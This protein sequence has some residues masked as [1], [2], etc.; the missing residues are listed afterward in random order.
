MNSL[1]HIDVAGLLDVSPFT[2]RS[3]EG[4][5][6]IPLSRFHPRIIEWLEYNPFARATHTIPELLKVRRQ[7]LGLTQK[8]AA[9][10]FGVDETT[11]RRW[12]RGGR[13]GVI[14]HRRLL[15]SF[16]GVPEDVVHESVGYL[17]AGIPKGIHKD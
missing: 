12:E 10:K 8:T 2:Y 5:S 3:W 17:Q 15:A 4:N 7:E 6:S 13:L 9:K 14:E 11:F 1:R 16:I